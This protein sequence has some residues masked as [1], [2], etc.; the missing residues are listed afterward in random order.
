MYPFPVIIQDA[1]NEEELSLTP[2]PNNSKII[3]AILS[4]D[5]IKQVPNLANAFC[6]F[7]VLEILEFSNETAPI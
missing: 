1:G 4:L 2:P 7:C 5:R 3:T 6:A